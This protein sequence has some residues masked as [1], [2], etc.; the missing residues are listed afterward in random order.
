MI[1]TWRKEL[2]RATASNNECLQ[3]LVI[4]IDELDLDKEFDSDYGTEEGVP[5]TAWSGK[6]VYFPVCY[7]GREWV[8]SVPRNPN[9]VRT[10]H[11]G[12]G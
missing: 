1:T 2:T 11:Q 8:G 10:D 4:A 7:D 12:G 3:D 5:F 6:F 9:D